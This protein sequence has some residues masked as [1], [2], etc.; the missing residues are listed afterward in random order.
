MRKLMNINEATAAKSRQTV[1]MAL[2]RMNDALDENQYL[3]GNRFSRADLTAAALLAPLFT[4]PQY[5]LDWPDKMPEPLQSEVN[6]LEP[7]LVWAKEIY[8]KHR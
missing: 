1:L 3:V 5:G 7:Q 4:P 2:E 6:A 8:R